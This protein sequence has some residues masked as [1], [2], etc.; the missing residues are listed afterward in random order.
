MN[1]SYKCAILNEKKGNRKRLPDIVTAIYMTAVS[2]C[3]SWR[4]F[5][6]TLENLIAKTYKGNNEYTK[7]NQIRICNHRI[8]LLSF[9]WRVLFYPS[10]TEGSRLAL[11]SL[12]VSYHDGSRQGNHCIVLFLKIHFAIFFQ[13][14]NQ[15]AYSLAITYHPVF[16]MLF[17]NMP[18]NPFFELE[19]RQMCLSYHIR[20][21]R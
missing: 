14:G 6:F 20:I 11:V 18:D 16:S 12:S 3:S 19:Q 4:L 5:S 15:P 7:L 17:V 9:V 2:Y 10:V 8:A 13:P 1:L 21:L